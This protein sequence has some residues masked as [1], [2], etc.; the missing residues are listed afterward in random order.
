M[1]PFRGDGYDSGPLGMTEYRPVYDAICAGDVGSLKTLFDAKP[2]LLHVRMDLEYG[3]TPLHVAASTGRLRIVAWLVEHGAEINAC[4]FDGMTPFE[5]AM[6]ALAAHESA[7]DQA[8]LQQFFEIIQFF[9]MHGAHIPVVGEVHGLNDELE[10]F[11]EEV[12]AALSP[13][14]RVERRSS[15]ERELQ[16]ALAEGDSHKLLLAGEKLSLPEATPERCMKAGTDDEGLVNVNG[17]WI[18]SRL[19]PVHVA[20]AENRLDVLTNLIDANP[21][22]LNALLDPIDDCRTL[23]HIAADRGHL[24]IVEWLVEQGAEIDAPATQH[25][26]TPLMLAITKAG[27]NANAAYASIVKCLTGR[28]AYIPTGPVFPH[29]KMVIK[30]DVQLAAVYRQLATVRDTLP[31]GAV[32]L[33]RS[34]YERTVAE[35]LRA[36]A[37]KRSSRFGDVASERTIAA[38]ER[39][40]ISRRGVLMDRLLLP[41]LLAIKA[42]DPDRLNDELDQDSELINMRYEYAEGLTRDRT[43]LSNLCGC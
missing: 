43:R 7:P 34:R 24:A 14:E 9:S 40:A 36:R 30:Q 31:P 1:E 4:T 5:S 26:L 18:D 23:L 29:T 12:A 3:C 19:L 35:C 6:R 27:G 25:G 33:R 13:T 28:G 21:A 11:C 38:H 22:L 37:R 15:Y 17:V 2:D 20:I 8:N 42:S 41:C 39:L 32:K 10:R 16:I